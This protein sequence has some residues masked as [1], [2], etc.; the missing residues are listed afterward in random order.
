MRCANC[1]GQLPGRTRFCPHCS[2]PWAVAFEGSQAVGGRSRLSYFLGVAV[3]VLIFVA[4]AVIG[5]A[6][7]A[8]GLGLAEGFPGP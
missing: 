3:T 2:A 8:A 7:F 1:G 6:V 4:T 5:F